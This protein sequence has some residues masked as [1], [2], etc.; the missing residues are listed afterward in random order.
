LSARVPERPGTPLP[1][2]EGQGALEELALGPGVA[3]VASFKATAV[4]LIK[5]P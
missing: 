1:L 5:Q 4:H 3:V 2:L